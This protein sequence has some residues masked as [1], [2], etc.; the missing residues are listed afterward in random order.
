MSSADVV[1]S[2]D[3]YTLVKP[4]ALLHD[5][6]EHV[7]Q[8]EDSKVPVSLRR[9]L[10]EW[11]ARRDEVGAKEKEEGVEDV[12]VRALVS[13]GM[14]FELIRRLHRQLEECPM[15]KGDFMC[16]TSPQSVCLSLQSKVMCISMSLWKEAS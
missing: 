15:G 8:L 9:E 14:E 6:V 13:S 5:A 11:R 1:Y 16:T 7:L 10:L 2:H 4:T 3:S 12:D